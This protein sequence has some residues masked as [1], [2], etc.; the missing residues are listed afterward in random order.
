MSAT[1]RQQSLNF[2]E[3]IV[4]AVYVDQAEKKRRESSLIISGLESGSTDDCA[5]V[6]DLCLTELGVTPDII[7]TKRLGH[8]QPGKIQPLLVMLRRSEQPSGS[9]MQRNLYDDRP[10]QQSVIGCTS[11]EISRVLKPKRP[12]KSASN[13]DELLPLRSWQHIKHPSCQM[14]TLVCPTQRCNAPFAGLTMSYC[15]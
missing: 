11:I 6:A 9:L 5:L 10:I 1:Y 14:W 15:R 12:T 2:R 3:N 7:S 13:A 4:A 8:S